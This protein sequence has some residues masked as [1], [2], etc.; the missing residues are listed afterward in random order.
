MKL[1]VADSSVCAWSRNGPEQREPGHRNCADCDLY[2]Q[3]CKEKNSVPATSRAEIA[4]WSNHLNSMDSATRMFATVLWGGAIGLERRWRQRMTGLRTNG[5]VAVGAAVSVMMGG[6]VGGD[7]NQGRAA[8][9]VVSGI[10]FLG[11]GAIVYR[12]RCSCRTADETNIRAMPMQEAS[13]TALTV[14]AL[15]SF[16]AGLLARVNVKAYLKTIARMKKPCYYSC[17]R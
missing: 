11:G 7:G 15:H 4:V 5:L 8:S 2:E 6:L 9:H 1:P 3:G 12:L 13:R 10:G 17:G 14:I 16:D